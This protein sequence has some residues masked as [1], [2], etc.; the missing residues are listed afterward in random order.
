MAAPLVMNKL[1]RRIS[2]RVIELV[3][4][5]AHAAPGDLI[6]S[7]VA[8]KNEA[9]PLQGLRNPGGVDNMVEWCA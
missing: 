6:C 8:E 4:C 5:G 2:T 3:E 7:H 9:G 1:I